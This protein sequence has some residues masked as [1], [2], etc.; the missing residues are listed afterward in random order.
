MYSDF[1]NLYADILS[2]KDIDEFLEFAE[3]ILDT[4]ILWATYLVN[5]LSTTK[6]KS[7]EYVQVVEKTTRFLDEY[8]N[9]AEK[10]A[11]IAVAHICLAEYHHLIIKSYQKITILK[12]MNILLVCKDLHY[13]NDK[14]CI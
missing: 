7:N 4:G 2:K 9:S 14:K 11:N 1:I 5:F 10:N 13:I 6:I 12:Q 8:K 3:K